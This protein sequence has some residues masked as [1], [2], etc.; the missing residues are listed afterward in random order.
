MARGAYNFCFKV[1]SEDRLA[2]FQKVHLIFPRCARVKL[3]GFDFI[4]IYDPEILKKLFN[5]QGAC[6][7]PFRNCLQLQKGLLSSECEYL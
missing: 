7:R 3:P 2:E 5:A 6:Q 1:K 4:A